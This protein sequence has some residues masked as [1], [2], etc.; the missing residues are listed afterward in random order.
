[1]STSFNRRKFLKTSLY[2]LG[3]ITLLS[4]PAKIF[5]DTSPQISSSTSRVDPKLLYKQAKDFFHKKEYAVATQLYQQLLTAYPN[6]LVYYDGYAKVLGAQQKTLAVAEL[7]RQGMLSNASSPHFK[8]R[9]ALSLRN[10]CIGNHK[11]ELEFTTKY[12][13]NNLMNLSAALMLE[14]VAI[15]PIRG[16]L[17]DMRDYPVIVTRINENPTRKP[18]TVLKIEES[19]LAQITN[20]STAVEPKWTETRTSR[21]PLIKNVDDEVEAIN[22]KG[23]RNLYFEKEKQSRGK[24]VKK[25]KKERWRKAM[26]DNMQANN[27]SQAEKYATYILT[28]NINDTDTIGKMRKFFRKNKNFDRLITLNRNLYAADSSYINALTLASTLV[29]YGNAGSDLAEIKTLLT[30]VKPY[31]TTLPTV[32]TTSYYLTLA[33]VNLRENLP[34]QARSILLEGIGLYDGRGG[35]S[36]S[37]IELYALSFLS[38]EPQKG[39]AV[40]KTLLGKKQDNIDPLIK[41]Y[42]LNQLNL[43]EKERSTQEKIKVLIALSKLQKKSGDSEYNQTINEL[44]ALKATLI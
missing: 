40:L 11:A 41:N 1:M 20:L 5:A 36:Y 34:E 37:M 18:K 26:L 22:G 24:G 10:L 43:T 15:K 2:S 3:S 4:F 27:M 32:N 12:G 44:N 21:K 6:T 7:Y 23:R 28:D 42:V 30:I 29:K 31:I 19:I 35:L 13:Q 14:A 25:A 17:M 9:F 38:T 39:I 16:Y 33:Q 8:H